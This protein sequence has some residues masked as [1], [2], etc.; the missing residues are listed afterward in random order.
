MMDIYAADMLVVF[1]APKTSS[2]AD[3]VC[4][5]TNPGAKP[6]HKKLST[7]SKQPLYPAERQPKVG[8][9]KHPPVPKLAILR[10][11]KKD[12]Q[13]TGGPTS[14]GVISETRANPQLSS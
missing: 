1:K 7:S 14:L 9:P 12:Q 5:G 6:G 8:L 10:K 3:S 11:E 4:Q 13:V 2:K